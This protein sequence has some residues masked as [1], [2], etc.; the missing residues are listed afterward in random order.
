MPINLLSGHSPG[1]GEATMECP[2]CGMAQLVEIRFSVGGEST[3]MRSCPACERRWW[4]TSG[5][6]VELGSIL[7]LAAGR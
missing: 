6:H 2:S 4:E 1:I 7:E 3:T 5:H